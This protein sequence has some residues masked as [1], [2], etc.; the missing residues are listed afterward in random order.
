MINLNNT[1]KIG[2]LLVCIVSLTHTRAEAD[3][4]QDTSSFASHTLTENALQY[5]Q[6]VHDKLLPQRKAAYEYLQSVTK[7]RRAR[8]IERKRQEM[9]VKIK[10]NSDYFKTYIPFN[11]DKE[12]K[13]ELLAY[14]DMKYMVLK[15]DFDKIV[16]MEKVEALTIDQEDAHQMAL[17]LAF[18]KLDTCFAKYARAEDAFFI[19]YNIKEDT[20][21]DAMSQKIERANKLIDYYNSIHRIFYKVNK[22]SRQADEAVGRRDVAALEQHA[23]TMVAYADEA[24]EKLKQQQT[25]EGDSDLISAAKSLTEF[26]KKEGMETIPLNVKYNLSKDLF[27]QAEKK[28]QSIK[29]NDRKDTDINEYNSAVREFNKAVKEINKANSQS[30]KTHKQLIKRWNEL[31]ETFFK[32]HA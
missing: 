22:I 13:D 25:F 14:L 20:V 1:L 18:A 17:D 9:I 32:K 7:S 29:E 3:T 24:I 2:I 10:E 16:D 26:Y 8:I 4:S 31:A 12:Y 11:N 30:D 27:D 19:R 15:E 28:F 6:G 21:K 23:I 5:L